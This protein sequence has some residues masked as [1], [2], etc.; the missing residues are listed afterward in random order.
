MYVKK[1]RSNS[2]KG[3]LRVCR[4]L[5]DNPDT[6]RL[7]PNTVSF[8]NK[9]LTKMSEKY[10]SLYIKPDIGSQGIGI[11]KLI[12]VSTGYDLFSIQ[13]KEQKRQ[14]FSN[15]PSL[16]QYLAAHIQKKMIIQQGIS[17]AKTNGRPYD[18]R[19]MVQRKPKGAWTCTG[20][21][22]KVGRPKKIVTNH[23]QG[24]KVITMDTLLK[25]MGLSLDRRKAR[26]RHLSDKGVTVS[27]VLSAKK[28][29]MYE[30]GIDFAYDNHHRI[31]ILEVN[32]NHPQF[33]PLKKVD[34]SAYK[35]IRSFA[36]SYGRFDD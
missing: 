20:L 33:F 7:V 36:R 12:R 1:Y 23:Y 34:L 8:S 13:K 22:V 27:R 24:G 31:W 21:L 14:H 10:K 19:V 25:Q 6:K 17:L 11:F 15:L 32:S 3:K 30:M 18:I 28:S 29:G 26:I 2:L 9:N 5:L 16:F 4:Y 35:R